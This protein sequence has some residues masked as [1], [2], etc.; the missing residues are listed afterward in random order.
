MDAA[1]TRPGAERRKWRLRLPERL[2]DLK[3]RWLTLY[4]I[5][6]AIVFPLAIIGAAKGAY[7]SITTPTMWSAYGLSTTE[8]SKGLHVDSV[9]SPPARESGLEAGDYVIAVDGWT[10][11]KMAARS[12]ARAHVIKPDGSATVFTIRKPDG[13]IFDIRLRRSIAFERERFREAGVSF[14]TARTLNIVGVLVRA[15]LFI[16]AAVLM[17]WRR[18][19]EVVPA[20]LSLAFLLFAGISANGDMLG[21]GIDALNI[22]GASATVLLFLAIFA[23]PSGRFEPRWTSFALVLLVLIALVDS[24]IVGL[25]AVL[26]ALA[27]LICR[28]RAVGPGTERLQLRW[29]FFGL[30]LGMVLFGLLLAGNIAVAAWQAQDPRW[31][32]W[33]YAIFGPLLS[34][35]FCVMALGLIVSILRYRLYDADAVIGRSAAYGI[36]TVGFVA[37]FAASQKIIEL[38]G[39]QFLGQ[40]IGGLAGG[41]GA[42]IAAVAIAPMHNRAQRWAERRFQKP[43][44]RLR[45]GLPALVGDLRETSGLEQVVAATLDSLVDGVRACRAAVVIGG[46]VADAREIPALEVRRWMSGW[47]PPAH[48]GID[49]NRNDATFPVRVPLE[50]EGH[51]RV[52]WLLLGPRP[53]GSLFGKAEFDAIEDVAEPVARAIQV[54]MA[55]QQREAEYDRRIGALEHR[56]AELMKK[57]RER[58][59]KATG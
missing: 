36:L 2:P 35:T 54:A 43:L 7:I 6:W 46:E 32:A 12:E 40:N 52:G 21:I 23:F 22:I 39:Q 51:G 34:A 30:V 50:A 25:I 56:L 14:A 27:V 19:S 17:F 24:P 8:D 11:P 31:V 10:V 5:V 49:C 45:H 26:S 16:A 38:I 33:E 57:L 42:A 15:T 29:A 18:R 55:R 48:D 44:Y 20:S 59:S 41:I 58:T 13:R 37:L 3:G 47:S 1:T 28:Y 53:D 9:L 4:T